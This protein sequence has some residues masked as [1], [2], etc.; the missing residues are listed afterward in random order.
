MSDFSTQ[1]RHIVRC[2][3]NLRE[4]KEILGGV[5]EAGEVSHGRYTASG[6]GIEEPWGDGIWSLR[7]KLKQGWVR[8]PIIDLGDGVKVPFCKVLAMMS[9]CDIT[10]GKEE[11]QQ[12]LVWQEMHNEYLVDGRLWRESE[13]TRRRGVSITLLSISL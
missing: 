13:K 6:I 2:H 3:R 12:I 9:Q 5:F 1:E 8:G 4:A 11:C 10:E 7:N